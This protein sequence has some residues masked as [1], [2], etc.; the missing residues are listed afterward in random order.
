MKSD[1]IES[2]LKKVLNLENIKVKNIENHFEIIAID[3]IFKNMS[4]VEKQ[5]I[6]YEPLANYIA[7]NVIHSISIETYTPNEWISY[8]KKYVEN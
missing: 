6:I 3:N 4:D 8:K 1:E 7:N 2:L 5:K